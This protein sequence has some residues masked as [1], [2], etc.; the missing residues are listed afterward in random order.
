MLLLR[1]VTEPQCQDTQRYDTSVRQ[2]MDTGVSVL[3]TVLYAGNSEVGNADCHLTVVMERFTSGSDCVLRK[4][5]K[6][7]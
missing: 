3:L 1:G 7:S 4:S 2:Q 5:M 6:H